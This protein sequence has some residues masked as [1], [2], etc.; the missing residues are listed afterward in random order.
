MSLVGA[1]NLRISSNA[2]IHVVNGRDLGLK[3][4]GTVFKTDAD[5]LGLKDGAIAAGHLEAGLAAQLNL[6]VKRATWTSLSN[7][8]NINVAEQPTFLPD[9]MFVGKSA[10][11]A[12]NG[13]G[14]VGIVA[15]TFDNVDAESG[16][17]VGQAALGQ[18]PAPDR[19]YPASH[20]AGQRGVSV[21]LQKKDGDDIVLSELLTAAP[22]DDRNA[23]VYGHLSHRSD[24]GANA[25]W[26]LWLY[27]RRSDGLETPF[28]PDQSLNTVSIHVAEVFSVSDLPVRAGLGLVSPAGQAAA[29]VGPKAI[30]TVELD[31][32]SVT[33]G[34]VANGAIGAQ[35]LANGAVDGTKLALE[36]VD[37]SKLKTK[38]RFERLVGNASNGVT[39]TLSRAVAAGRE[40]GVQITEDTAPV[41]FVSANPEVSPS[42]AF[43]VAGATVTL[44]FTQ[45]QD[46]V[47]RCWYDSDLS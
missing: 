33:A 9:A 27:Y 17:Q 14:T 25:H 15:G 7:N 38:R 18:T 21:V 41:D 45:V 31:D 26:R 30:G 10:G 16:N 42:K 29:A 19:P 13:N 23:R 12:V 37:A 35:A 11:G 43:T 47:Y 4:N 32:A 28:M 5:G 36:A 3:V 24:L 22:D 44:G 1:Q 40:E 34:K 8:F 6:T 2:G 20:F 46:A 39:L